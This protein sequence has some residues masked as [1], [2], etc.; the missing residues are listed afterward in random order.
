MPELTSID[1]QKKLIASLIRQVLT[2][3]ICARQALEQFPCNI[4]DESFQCVWHALIHFE[5]DEDLRKRDAEY[6]EVQ[7]EYLK[8]LIEIFEKGESLP[9]NIIEEYNKFYGKAVKT[10][11]KD[12]F[13][14]VKSIF[15]FIN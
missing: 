8:E 15:R 12:F 5:A 9:E 6:A 1:N 3:E 10:D 2:G 7:D 11:S 4:E 14:K 13:S